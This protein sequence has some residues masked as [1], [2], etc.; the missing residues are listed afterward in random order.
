MTEVGKIPGK[1]LSEFIKELQ[2]LEKLHGD[3]PVCSHDRSWSA[4][5]PVSATWKPWVATANE[6]F[7][8]LNYVC[9][10]DCG[11]CATG[12]IGARVNVVCIV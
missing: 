2:E 1:R 10:S 9:D 5:Y 7:G 4:W 6:N 12:D 11:Y 3:M 8:C